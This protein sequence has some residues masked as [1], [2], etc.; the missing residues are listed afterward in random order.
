MKFQKPSK[1]Q[2]QALPLG[3]KD[4]PENGIYQARSGHGKT[5]AFSL[6]MLMR[7]DEAAA[8]AQALCLAPVYELA[9]QT[10][11]VCRLMG[12]SIGATTQLAVADSSCHFAKGEVCTKHIIIGDPIEKMK[13]IAENSLPISRS[14]SRVSSCR[15]D[16]RV[17]PGVSL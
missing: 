8:Q 12:Q 6:I 7:I 13:N 3:L 4:P 16:G 14:A 5:C 11:E 2:E 15:S 9:I 17:K 10:E 1:I